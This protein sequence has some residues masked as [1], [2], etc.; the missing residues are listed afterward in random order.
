M[1]LHA[2]CIAGGQL[3]YFNSYQ[4]S[5]S[6]ALTHQDLL[7]RQFECPTQH[8]EV[9]KL[10]EG[11]QGAANEQYERDVARMA[12]EKP[13]SVSAG[14]SVLD[15]DGVLRLPGSAAPQAQ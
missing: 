11:L 12:G 13:I 4:A 14:L 5:L 3:P 10:P 8:Q 6:S 1:L 9:F 15:A 7:H 2:H